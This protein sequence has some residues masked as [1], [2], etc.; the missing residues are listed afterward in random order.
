[1]A[2]AEIGLEG[3]L[4]KG[5]E[6]MEDK[7]LNRVIKMGFVYFEPSVSTIN[8]MNVILPGSTVIQLG[9]F[10]IGSRG[11]KRFLYLV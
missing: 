4:R 5:T 9:Y 11:L 1:M 3:A 7:E 8:Q 2:L 6:L 10:H